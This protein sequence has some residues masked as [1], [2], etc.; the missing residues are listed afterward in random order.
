MH[1]V[2]DALRRRAL[3]GVV[4]LV[5][6]PSGCEEGE[7]SVAR[8]DRLWADSAYTAALAEYRLAYARN[9]APEVLARVAHGYAVTGQFERAREHYDELVR[10]APEYTDQ[11]VFDYLDLARRAE[12]RSDRYGM[13]GAIEA[14]VALRP[15]LPVEQMTLPLARY[16]AANGQA[17]RALEF[18]DR[19]LATAPG[20]SVADLLFEMAELQESRGDCRQA[21]ELYNAFRSRAGADGRQD[22]AAYQVGAC[23]WALAKA[24]REGGDPER[25]LFLI[26]SVTSM[27]VPQTLQD[28]A[29]FER[30]EI[31]FELGRMDE[32]LEAYTR[33]IEA[34]QAPRS[35]LSERARQRI[36]QI[37][38]GRMSGGGGSPA[39][40]L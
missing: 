7:S 26:E 36:D 18:Y 6:A 24:A 8:G 9:K 15:G 4:L 34:S 11:A 20:D 22:R 35:Q 17:E 13:A 33:S 37:R 32:A 14:A 27:G 1:N 5:L 28:E 3:L 16:Y 19:A 2:L 21:I 40:N 29:W 23:S 10:R 30:G 31:L 39:P 38:F 12:S 25:A